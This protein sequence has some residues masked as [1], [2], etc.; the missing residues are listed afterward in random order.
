M[1]RALLEMAPSADAGFKVIRTL[2]SNWPSH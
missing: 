2:V 1:S